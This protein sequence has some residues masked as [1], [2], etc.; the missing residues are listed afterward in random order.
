MDSNPW[1]LACHPWRIRLARSEMVGSVE[2]GA[3]LSSVQ[4]WSRPVRAGPV[5]TWLVTGPGQELERWQMSRPH[6]RKVAVIQGGDRVR[7]QAL[8]YRDHGRV[9]QAQREVTVGL[10]Q[11]RH[12]VQI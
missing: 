10:H 8:G 2:V 12:P 6:Y 11:F 1:P 3:G 5:V 7:V 9:D 4:G